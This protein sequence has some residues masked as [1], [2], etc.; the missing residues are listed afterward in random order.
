MM[1]NTIRLPENESL[2]MECVYLVY[3]GWRLLLCCSFPITH[4]FY[5]GQKR[6]IFP[7]LL[8]LYSAGAHIVD[9]SASFFTLLFLLHLIPWRAGLLSDRPP[10]ISAEL[11]IFFSAPMGFQEIG[12]GSLSI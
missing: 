5:T 9:A 3:G 1:M 10:P 4:S 2:Y 12:G 6:L 7:T 11:F 8:I